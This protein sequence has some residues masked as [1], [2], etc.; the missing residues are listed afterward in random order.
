MSPGRLAPSPAAITSY[1]FNKIKTCLV[2]PAEGRGGKAD[3]RAAARAG[4]PGA[5]LEATRAVS[6]GRRPPST[7]G[8]WAAAQQAP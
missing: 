8:A 1:L 7:P 6:G 4:Q 5:G 2:G 3:L